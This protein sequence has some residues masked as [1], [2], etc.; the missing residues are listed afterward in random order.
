MELYLNRADSG[1][2]DHGPLPQHHIRECL[3][4][5]P[6]TRLVTSGSHSSQKHLLPGFDIQ[7]GHSDSY[8]RSQPSAS[9]QS[10]V[11][12]SGPPSDSP[13]PQK[14]GSDQAGVPRSFTKG[15]EDS[16]PTA[17]TSSCPLQPLNQGW[18]RHHL[19]DDAEEITGAGAQSCHCRPLTRALHQ[20]SRSYSKEI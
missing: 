7:L 18:E 1:Y 13:H 16:L 3:N 20:G 5:V 11:S 12:F 8:E 9:A 19:G 17:G 6:T 10:R 2:C 15:T 14:G 4:S